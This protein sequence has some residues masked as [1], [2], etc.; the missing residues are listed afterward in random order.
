MG[1]RGYMFL[2]NA[3][4]T[5]FQCNFVGRAIFSKRLKETKLLSVHP[6]LVVLEATFKITNAKLYVH[7]AIKANA[8]F[9]EQVK[10]G[11]K[12]IS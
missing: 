2:S 6:G 8:K 3:R 5:K 9:L 10:Q 7:L 4:N 11:S 12:N 1:E